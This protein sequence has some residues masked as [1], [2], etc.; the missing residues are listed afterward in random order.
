MIHGAKVTLV[1]EYNTSRY[2]CKCHH[3][4][5]API[6]THSLEKILNSKVLTRK[7][8]RNGF[9]KVSDT[10]FVETLHGVRQCS[11]CWNSSGCPKF[12]MT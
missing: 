7:F 4:L 1:D 10:N 9:R 12:H 6:A 8:E 5:L 11:F 3:S 2:C